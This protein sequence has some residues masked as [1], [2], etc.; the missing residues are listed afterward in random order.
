M[1]SKN[2]FDNLIGKTIV[3]IQFNEDEEKCET[4]DQ[5]IDL[6]FSDGT[7]VLIRSCNVYGDEGAKLNFHT[8]TDTDCWYCY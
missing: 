5:M 7:S 2:R 1:S 8:Y 3:R 4:E 6:H